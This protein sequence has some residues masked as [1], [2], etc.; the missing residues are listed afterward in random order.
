MKFANLVATA[1]CLTTAALAQLPATGISSLPVIPRDYDA[2][3]QYLVLTDSQI[4]SLKQIQ[5]TRQRTDQSR[6]EQVSQKQQQL[7]ALLN[8]GSND[9]VAIGR[10]MI[11]INAMQ[12]QTPDSGAEYR[13]QALNVLTPQQKQ[14]L[15]S[16]AEALQL[17]PTAGEAIALNLIEPPRYDG[18]RILP[19][20]AGEAAT[21]LTG[22]VR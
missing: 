5:D 13:A 22:N 9:A 15:P 21:A 20:P 11:D 10:L 18:P 14:K 2:V 16:L 19:Y 6:W 7:Q 12:R 8:Q 17:A 3:R 4:A 1:L